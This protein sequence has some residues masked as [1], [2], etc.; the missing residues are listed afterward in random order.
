MSTKADQVQS[1]NEVAN[2]QVL[3]LNVS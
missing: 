3:A 2:E 1:S